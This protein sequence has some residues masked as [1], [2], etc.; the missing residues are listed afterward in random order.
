MRRSRRIF[1]IALVKEAGDTVESND[2]RSV[3]RINKGLECT[4]KSFDSPVKCDCQLFIHDGD[5]MK[6]WKKHFI[7][8]LN[9]IA[10]GEAAPFVDD[11]ARHRNIRIQAVPTSR[12]EMILAINSFKQSKTTGLDVLPGELHIYTHLQLLQLCTCS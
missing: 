10:F 11:M 9:L 3:Y 8:V 4:C 2:F 12:R 1:T 6:Q 5:Q 7:I